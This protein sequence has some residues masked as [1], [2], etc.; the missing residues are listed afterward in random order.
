MSAFQTNLSIFTL[1]RH[2]RERGNL[3][4]TT[5]SLGPNFRKTQMPA[6]AGMTGIGD[7]GARP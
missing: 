7:I 2:S 5:Y 6:F 4:W 3:C 1:F